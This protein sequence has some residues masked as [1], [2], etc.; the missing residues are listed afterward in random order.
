M[1]TMHPTVLVG[2][3]DWDPVRLPQAEF[4]A[5]LA[6]FWGHCDPAIA[7]AM[8]FGGPHHHAELAWLTHFTPKLEGAIA[9]IPRAGAPR[10]LVG[11]GANMLGAAKPLTWVETLLPLRDAGT[12]IAR[13]HDEIGGLALVN[14]DAMPFG[15]R[16]SIDAAL[17]AA[18]LDA[19]ALVTEAMRRKSSRELA[20]IRE[21]CAG[22]DAALSA[23]YDAQRTRMAL[24]DVV[25]AG[26]RAARQRGAQD[27]RTLFGREGRL[28]PFTALDQA[29]AD[30]LQVYVAVRQDGYWAEGFAALSQSALPAAEQARATLTE[31]LRLIGPGAP[32]R[33]PAE[34]LAREVGAGRM[35][36]VT[37][38]GFGGPMGLA[39][40]APECLTTA[41]RGHFAAR[42]VFSLRVGLQGD[43]GA[44]VVSAMIVI[45]ETGHDVLWPGAT[46]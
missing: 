26:E 18:P 28:A 45:T 40:D 41:S 20:M 29:I 21:A 37:R 13:W 31:A 7:G 16:Q 44:A 10:L 42:E 43:G 22:L 11:G 14:G 25:L 19:T 24:S 3:A 32:Y 30:P 35:H 17:G 46:P 33:A 15:L 38:N 27:V 9:L 39:L 5:R 8:V 1:L 12:T 2:P 23:M 6:A 4:A 36:P 34:L